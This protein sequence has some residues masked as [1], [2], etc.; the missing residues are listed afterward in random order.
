MKAM[1]QNNSRA[2]AVTPGLIG[3]SVGTVV[4]A[5]IVMGYGLLPTTLARTGDSGDGQIIRV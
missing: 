5:M 3:A 4:M 1:P 2:W